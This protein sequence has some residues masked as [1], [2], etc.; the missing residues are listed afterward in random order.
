M[1]TE[2]QL[3]ILSIVIAAFVAIAGALIPVLIAIV[4]FVYIRRFEERMTNI[5]DE[6][7]MLWDRLTEVEDSE[8][9][10]NTG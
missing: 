9:K 10:K 8:R 1:D 4:G 3:Q 7:D 2:L 6:V 5:S